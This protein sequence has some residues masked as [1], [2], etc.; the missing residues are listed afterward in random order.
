MPPHNVAVAAQYRVALGLG[1]DA[2]HQQ[3]LEESYRQS[4]HPHG[5]PV[6]VHEALLHSHPPPQTPSVVPGPAPGQFGILAPTPIPDVGPQPPTPVFAQQQVVER[7]HGQLS[8]RIVPNPPDLQM[9]REKLFNV[10]E[11]IV[12]TNDQ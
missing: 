6:P 8:S 2:Y 11:V 4:T 5:V 9:W 1:L 7:S 3:T 10:D 12:L